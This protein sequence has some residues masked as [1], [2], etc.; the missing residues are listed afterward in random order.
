VTSVR[1]LQALPEL[2]PEAPGQRSTISDN[3][4]N[5]FAD[6]HATMK[7]NKGKTFVVRTL[8]RQSRW[9]FSVA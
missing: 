9:K 4:F 6:A 8:N 1:A 3:K 2:Y 7:K 5:N